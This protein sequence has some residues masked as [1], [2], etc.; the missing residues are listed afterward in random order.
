MSL[1]GLPGPHFCH[2]KNEN[3]NNTHP[4][5]TQ[6]R[7]RLSVNAV[8]AFAVIAGVMNLCTVKEKTSGPH[9]YEAKSSMGHL[10]QVYGMPGR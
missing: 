3:N 7:V 10:R 1:G 5:G 9:R 8:F 4:I 6:N 2:W